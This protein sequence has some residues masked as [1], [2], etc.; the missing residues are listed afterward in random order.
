VK[1]PPRQVQH[2]RRVLAD[3]VEHDR[4]SA[5]G[6]PLADDVDAFGLEPLK[7]GQAIGQ[8]IALLV[9]PCRCPRW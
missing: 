8:P 9:L 6:G 2:H 1:G 5:L 4:V 7:M 3:R